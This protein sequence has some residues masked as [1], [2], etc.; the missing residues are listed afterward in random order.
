MDTQPI[1]AYFTG[2]QERIVTALEALDGQPFRR[3]EW[4]RPQGGGGC[5]RLIEEGSFFE[6]GGVNFSHVTGDAMP[7]SATA[8]PASACVMSSIPGWYAA[9]RWTRERRPE[10]KARA[11]A[12][13]GM[14]G[15]TAAADEALRRRIAAA[16]GGGL[17][18]QVWPRAETS[19][20]VNDIAARLRV[21]P[22]GDLEGRL[23]LAGLSDHMIEAGDMEQPC[24][25]CMYFEI[26]RKFCA[27]PELMLPVEPH[28][29]CRLW[30]I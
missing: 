21:L 27:L 25:T 12:E 7:A 15:D 8:Q 22:P 17:A 26:H 16:L 10:W 4:T 11:E 24:A 3:D 2:L 1:H 6:R 19:E 23:V 13:A 28:W 30:R 14:G 9:R 18:T 29:S 20:M 5:S